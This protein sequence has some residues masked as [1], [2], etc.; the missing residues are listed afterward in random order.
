MNTLINVKEVK[1]IILNGETVNE[2]NSFLKEKWILLH[3]ASTNR[4]LVVVLG[5]TFD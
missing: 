2:V 5:R 3:L 4:G 1:E